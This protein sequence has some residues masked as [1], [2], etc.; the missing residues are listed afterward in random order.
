MYSLI[1]NRPSVNE[2][3][4]YQGIFHENLVRLKIETQDQVISQQLFS[5]LTTGKATG[6]QGAD[7][8]EPHYGIKAV[9]DNIEVEMLLDFECAWIHI[10]EDN[11]T[12]EYGL[13]GSSARA[14]RDSLDV[15]VGSEL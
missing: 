12:F 15:V 11:V 7:C 3:E 9:I 13:G 5:V 10:F 6:V 14:L 2:P 1:A 8:F 4:K